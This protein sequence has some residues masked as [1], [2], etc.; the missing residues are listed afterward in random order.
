MKAAGVANAITAALLT[1]LLLN[2]PVLPA[3]ET[4]RSPWWPQFHGPNRDN[5]SS[6]TGL[7]KE[8]PEGG[9]RLVWKYSPCGKGFSM[10]SIAG[11]RIFTAGDFDDEEH[12]IALDM[13]GRLLWR[14]AN[15]HSW[16]GPEPGSR[17]TPTYD[18]G[19]VYQMNPTGRL[20]AY[21][22]SSGEPIWSVDL[23]SEFG[24]R[25]GT[26]AMAENVVVD[27]DHVFCVPGGSKGIVA[28]LDKHTGRT[29]WAGTEPDEVAAYCSPIVVTYRG[30]RQLI[31]LT[32]KS[33]IG[34]DVHTGKLLWSHPH[35]TPHDQN[36]NAPRFKDGYVFVASGHHGGAALLK[37]DENLRGAKEV[38]SDRDLD[39]CHGGVILIDGFL[40]GSACRS[41]GKG[42]FCADFFT[43]WVTQRDRTLGKLSLTCADG[44]LYGLSDRG[45]TS[46]L[47]IRP[48]VFRPV[49][50][51]RIPSGGT[52]PSLAHP[53]VC[54]G[55]LY[56]RHDNDLYAY[57]VK[58]SESSSTLLK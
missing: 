44:M 9:P 51:F 5:I 8:W 25:F 11:G 18:D 13:N 46:L 2:V 54:G 22:A 38:W 1:A 6:D 34:V 19:A 39:N 42:F 53:V 56:V 37:I 15:G 58:A 52:G 45:W 50:R 41:G 33:V 40:Y 20:T 27:G 57:D 30:V 17:T 21:R 26:W 35:E 47:A 16:R 28:A 32:Q 29:I 49:S 4:D 12:V 10:V 7:L 55:R 24:A 3:A 23:K 43:G 36:V 14:S 31:T 48:G